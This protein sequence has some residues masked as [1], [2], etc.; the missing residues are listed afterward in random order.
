MSFY[1]DVF[2]IGEKLE[3]MGFSV[4]YPESALTMKKN[5][6]FNAE[7]FKKVTNP[8][9][10]GELIKLHFQ[11]ILQSQFI[12]VVNNTKNGID[13]YIGANVLMELAIAFNNG[14]KI[15]LLNPISEN[16]PFQEEITAMSPIILSG[17]LKSLK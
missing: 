5:D 4:F 16:Q 1:K 7:N 17:K 11:K 14:L 2:L 10:K 9:R 3:K 6:D 8:K 15:Y 13:G 12:L